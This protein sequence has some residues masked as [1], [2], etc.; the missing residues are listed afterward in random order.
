MGIFLAVT[1]SIGDMEIEE[2]T[3]CSQAETPME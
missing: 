3:F 2:A 1:H